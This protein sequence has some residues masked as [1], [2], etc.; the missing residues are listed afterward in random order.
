MLFFR[1][2]GR[3]TAAILYQQR[4]TPG[5]ATPAVDTYTLQDPEVQRLVDEMN[6]TLDDDEYAA[7]GAEAAR[8]IFL[9]DIA[10]LPGYHDKVYMPVTKRVQ[11]FKVSP[12]TWYG[13]FYN[14]FT[15][16]TVAD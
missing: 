7:L 2:S 9:E 13:M 3:P 15:T 12:I 14:A 8:R 16:V 10:I 5:P 1:G 11:G 6:A 4:Y